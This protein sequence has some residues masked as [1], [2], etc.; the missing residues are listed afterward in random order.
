MGFSHTL[1]NC[2]IDRNVV[3]IPLFVCF[4]LCRSLLVDDK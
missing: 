2:T 4:C 3:N 1:S